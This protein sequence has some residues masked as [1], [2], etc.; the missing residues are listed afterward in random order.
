MIPTMA[1]TLP[2]YSRGQIS[3]AGEALISTSGPTENDL[4]VIN[5]WRAVHACPLLTIKT[6]LAAR[7]KRKSPSVLISQ[8]TKR[9]KAIELKL[10]ENRAHGLTMNLS[11]MQDI[12]G[13]RAVF[14]TVSEAEALLH[15]YHEQWK[16]NANRGG[17]LKRITNYIDQPKDTGYR[18]I[19]IIC[20]YNSEVKHHK[21]YDGLLIEIQLR[22]KLQHYWAMAVETVDFFTGQALKSNIGEFDWKRFF[23]LVSNEFARIEKRNLVPGAPVDKDAAK[24]ELKLFSKQITALEGFQTAQRIPQAPNFKSK[25]GQLYLLKL[26]LDRRMISHTVFQKEQIK[27]AQEKYLADEGSNKS[28]PAI[29]SL[30]VSVDSL[31]ALPKAYPS[32]FLDI[33]N[34]VHVLKKIIS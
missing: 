5:N 34:F 15:Y 12:G 11:Q 10:R 33:T 26:D 19:H 18:G 8:R 4:L 3:K 13:C 7:A 27:E 24:A 32:Y 25:P 31:N 29:Q 17:T 2:E 22:S 23:V 30:L 20:K 14:A 21:P 6:T 28:N 1:W 16:K 9:I